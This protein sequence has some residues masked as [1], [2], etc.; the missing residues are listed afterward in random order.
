MRRKINNLLGTFFAKS[1]KINDEPINKFSLIVIIIIDLFILF[2]V[3]SGLNDIGR[4]YISPNEAYPCYSSWQ[5]Y[6]N[7]DASEKDYQFIKEALDQRNSLTTSII[8]RKNL[9]TISPLCIEFNQ[10][11]TQLNQ[12]KNQGFIK[13]ITDKETETNRILEA[14]R[15]IRSQYD[16]TLLEQIAGQPK[17]LSINEVEAQQ[18]RKEIEKN[19]QKIGQLTKE[20]NQAKQDLLRQEESQ[21]Y[22]NLLKSS[23]QFTTVENGYERASFWYPTIQLILQVFFLAPLILIGLFI[24]KGAE[25]RGDGLL[26]LMSWHLLVIFFIPLIIKF[27]DFLQIGVFFEFLLEFVQVFLGGLVFLINYLYIFIIPLVG[28]L[29]IKFFQKIVFNT[30]NQAS[31]R[32]EKS[33][34]LRC[35]RKIPP[36]SAYCPHCGYNQ[37]VECVNC[38]NST[39]KHLGYCVH[40]GAVQN[41]ESST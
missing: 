29:M 25:N 21:N 38:D 18:A 3:F 27:F 12:A 17:E 22:L 5:S 35:A 20:I 15:T 6:Q 7:S 36:Q 34:C 10:V 30:K 41:T 40:C 16:S 26:A 13:I 4:W 37:Y 31:K 19:N 9:G 14:T 1:R 28:F 39:Y 33:K 32:V 11:K 24:H 8:E 23:A 2:N